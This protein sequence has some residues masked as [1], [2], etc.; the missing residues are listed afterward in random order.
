VILEQLAVELPKL[1]LFARSQGRHG[2]LLGKFVVG[3]REVLDRIADVVGEYFQH[4]L[5]ILL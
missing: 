4:L 3:E 2:A 5:D 1:A